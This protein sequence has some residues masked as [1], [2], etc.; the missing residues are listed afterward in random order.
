MCLR[1]LTLNRCVMNEKHACTN[2]SNTIC[3]KLRNAEQL[4]FNASVEV[5]TSL[6]A[7]IWVSRLTFAGISNV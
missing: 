3:D 5:T 6:R 4:V 2:N 7:K 1:T